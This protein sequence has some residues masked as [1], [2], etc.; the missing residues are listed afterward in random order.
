M[1]GVVTRAFLPRGFAFVLG[2]D[3][4][5]YFLNASELRGKPWSGESVHEGVALEFVPRANGAGGN[6]LRATEARTIGCAKERP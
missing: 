5:E 6:G 2:E 1:K 4:L 3:G